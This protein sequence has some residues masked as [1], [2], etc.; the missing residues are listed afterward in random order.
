MS[1]FPIIQ[2]Q[3]ADVDTE[4]PFYREVAWDYEKNAPIWK[5]GNPVMLEGKEAV[6]VWAWNALHTPRFRYEI[7]TWAYGNEAESL[8][9]QNYSD[10]LKQA[11]GIR[12]VRECLLIN[13]Y[14]TDVQNTSVSFADG[15]L[16]IACTLVTVYGEIDLNGD[17][18]INV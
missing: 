15:I 16:T 4:L 12:Y 6:Y 3:A 2:P 9:G 18:N 11:E 8:I 14:I 10:E 13:P 5:N 7:Y 17:V 1:L